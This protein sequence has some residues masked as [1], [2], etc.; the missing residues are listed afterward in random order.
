[1]IA[2]LAQGGLGNQ[3][4]QYATA[5]RLALQHNCPVVLD[6]HWFEHPPPGDTPRPLE[7][8]NYRANFRVATASELSRWT[9]MRSRWAKLLK[10][11]LPLHVILE[12][13]YG[14]N[15]KIL[16]A[17]ANSYLIGYW[18]SEAYFADIREQLLEELVPIK[19]PEPE[20]LETIE[21]MQHDDTVAVHIRRGDYVSSGA[22][23]TYHGLCSLDYYH[24]AF[25]YLAGRLHQPTFFVFSDDPAWVKLHLR[26]QYPTY[27]VEHNPPEKAFQDMR[28]M[29]MC[30]NHVIANSSFSW[31]GAWLSRNPSQIVIAPARWYAINRPTPDLIPNRWMQISG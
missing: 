26:S 8:T 28:L 5:R 3:L 21:K 2:F 20:D 11:L 14:V 27:F 19:Q 23:S 18:Q 7:L 17:P 6:Q 12:R 16:S 31:W 30:R 1:M 29:S 22:A 24:N 10:P 9:V 15:N 4:F 13:G 25:N